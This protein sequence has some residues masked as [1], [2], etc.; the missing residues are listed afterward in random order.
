M[1][2]PC[3]CCGV[4]PPVHALERAWELEYEES[5]DAIGWALEHARRLG[6]PYH[7]ILSLFVRGM[8]RFN[9]G[10]LSEGLRDLQEGMRLAEQN[11][12]RYWLSRFPNTLGWAFGELQDLDAALKLDIEGARVARENGY[13]K[14]EAQSHLNLAGIYLEAGEPQT[15]FDHLQR[16][17]KI[18][19]EDVWFRWRYYIRLKTALARYWI[20]RG[21]TRKAAGFAAEAVALAEPRKA[22]KHLAWAHKVLGD[23]AVMEERFGEARQE[24]AAALDVL[25]HHHCPT[26]EWRIWLA[27]AGMASSYRNVSLAE[28]YRG[29]CQSVIHSLADSI[30]DGTLRGQFLG[31]EAIR[32]ALV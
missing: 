12:E 10:R 2:A 28:H 20:S 23:V 29:R 27:A 19:A 25:R 32:K 26:L 22:R 15:A 17:E 1:P 11:N 5:E 31:S 13:G 3:R 4:G 30:T 9:Q 7:I 16:A 6:L 8:S 21:D 24:Y 14:P 18:F